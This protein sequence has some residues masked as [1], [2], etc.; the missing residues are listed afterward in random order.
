MVVKAIIPLRLIC[1][2]QLWKSS[3]VVLQM[4]FIY[5]TMSEVGI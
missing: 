5:V 2:P 4:L 1:G 3:G